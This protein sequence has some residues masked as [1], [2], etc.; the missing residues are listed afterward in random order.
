MTEIGYQ[1][2]HFYFSG[3]MGPNIFILRLFFE[4][5][6]LWVCDDFG[7]ADSFTKL[8][9]WFENLSR[10][11]PTLGGGLTL[12]VVR[13]YSKGLGKARNSRNVVFYSVFL[14]GWGA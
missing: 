4:Y 5:I 1:Y 10:L 14:V 11:V 9:P 13:V 3:K 2:I 7:V 8:G 12:G 6:G